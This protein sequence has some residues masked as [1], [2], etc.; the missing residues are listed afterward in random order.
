M[1]KGIKAF[2]DKIDKMLTSFAI[3][4]CGDKIDKMIKL[5]KAFIVSV[6]ELLSRAKRVF[7]VSASELSSDAKR[8]AFIAVGFFIFVAW[9]ATA[10]TSQDSLLQNIAH[11][12]LSEELGDFERRTKFL[13]LISQYSNTKD[14]E[15]TFLWHHNIGHFLIR[16][17]LYCF[18]YRHRR[19]PDAGA[20]SNPFPPRPQTIA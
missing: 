4:A 7:I 17:K 15:N 13:D 6:S 1:I 11:K 20:D 5:I 2:G 12:A 14:R 3:N 10:Q 8:R 19:R 18:R 9:Q 16:Y